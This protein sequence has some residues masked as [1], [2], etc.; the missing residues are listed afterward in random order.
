MVLRRAQELVDLYARAERG[1]S[2]ARRLPDTYNVFSLSRL[3]AHS[4]ELS[5]SIYSFIYV[6]IYSFGDACMCT[7]FHARR[8]HAMH[9]VSWQFRRLFMK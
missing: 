1:V 3:R 8:G 9:G 2:P 4:M 7:D 5:V 6:R